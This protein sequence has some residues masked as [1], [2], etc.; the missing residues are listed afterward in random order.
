M[1]R[2]SRTPGQF[3]DLHE[4]PFSSRRRDRYELERT[5]SQGHF[6]SVVGR[7][8]TSRM[9][10]L[11]AERRGAGRR[12]LC[13]AGGTR[14]AVMLRNT[15]KWVRVKGPKI[16]GCRTFIHRRTTQCTS[17]YPVWGFDCRERNRSKLGSLER[18]TLQGC[19]E[20]GRFKAIDVYRFSGFA[21]YSIV[22]QRSASM[23]ERWR[24]FVF[25][26]HIPGKIR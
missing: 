8:A 6:V 23:S 1:G 4:H 19:P 2:Q 18:V 10:R 14:V 7:R 11:F 13:G 3:P 9:A 5:L 21:S 15:S 20:P 17:R 12:S 26:C 16:A 24:S 25:F 22:L